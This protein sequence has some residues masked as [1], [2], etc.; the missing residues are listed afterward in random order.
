MDIFSLLNKANVQVDWIWGHKY[1]IVGMSFKTP[2]RTCNIDFHKPI[3][4]TEDIKV[5][6][7]IEDFIIQA[8]KD[9]YIDKDEYIHRIS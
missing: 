3:K 2:S 9:L 6:S 7:T 5:V 4:D 8:V 1:K